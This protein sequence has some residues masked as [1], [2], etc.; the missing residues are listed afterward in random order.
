MQE[1]QKYT[2]LCFSYLLLVLNMVLA[3][4]HMLCL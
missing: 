3:W 4:L 2:T 1:R